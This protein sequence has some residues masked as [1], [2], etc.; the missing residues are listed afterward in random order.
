MNIE[1]LALGT[2]SFFR[3]AVP[4]FT[5]KTW[6]V[7]SYASTDRKVRMAADGFADDKTRINIFHVAHVNRVSGTCLCTY[8]KKRPGS[9][10]RTFA[11]RNDSCQLEAVCYCD[12]MRL[13]VHRRPWVRGRMLPGCGHLRSN[14]SPIII[15]CGLITVLGLQGR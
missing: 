10:N 4:L 1:S 12:W 14:I 2:F 13:R 9:R 7:I 6:Q 11:H 3:W 15:R 5:F 8:G